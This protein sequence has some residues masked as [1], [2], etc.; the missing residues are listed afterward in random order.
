MLS[1]L[2]ER[3]FGERADD[4]LL[5]IDP[6]CIAQQFLRSC[7]ALRFDDQAIAVV[8]ELFCRFVLDRMGTIY[9]DCNRQLG[10]AGFATCFERG[11]ESQVSA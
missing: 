2:E 5:P 9:G 3:A 8:K 7:R 10:E 11:D 6:G 4:L 1:D